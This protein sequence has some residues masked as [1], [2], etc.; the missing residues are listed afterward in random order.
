VLHVP[1]PTSYNL[2]PPV[3]PNNESLLAAGTWCPDRNELATLRGNLQRSSTRLRRILSAP[4]F[5]ALFGKAQP[6]P[7]GK[8]Q[9]VW[10]MDD[11]LKVAPKGID[12]NHRYVLTP[13]SL[14]AIR[15]VTVWSRD[16]DLLKCRSF[17]VVLK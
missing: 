11:E 9:S 8:R 5:E 16:I 2:P 1:I 10:G 13:R 6:H 7:Q 15:R 17:A 4:A 14:S 12:K 3:K